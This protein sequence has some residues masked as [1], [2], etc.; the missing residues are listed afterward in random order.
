MSWPVDEDYLRENLEQ[1]RQELSDEWQRFDDACGLR[2]AGE[3]E[4]DTER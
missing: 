1:E 4:E 2:L 3:R